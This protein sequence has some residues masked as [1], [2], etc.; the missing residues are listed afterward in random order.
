MRPGDLV[1]VS[2]LAPN[3]HSRMWCEGQTGL[4]TKVAVNNVVTVY[5]GYERAYIGIERLEVISESR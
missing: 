2:S 3:K 5:F 4:V 1:R